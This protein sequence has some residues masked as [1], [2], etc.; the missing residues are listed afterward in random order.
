MRWLRVLHPY[1]KIVSF[2]GILM[3]LPAAVS[4][5]YAD[6]FA[7]QYL[8]IGAA[9]FVFGVAL[10]AATRAFRANLYVRHGFLLINLIWLTL[11]VYATVPLLLIIPDLTFT[12]AYFEAA[13]GLTASGG[14]VL[15]GLDDLPPSLNFWRGE[16]SWIGGMGLVVLATAILPFLGV[17]GSGMYQTELPGPI[18]DNQ[19][20]PHIAQTAKALWLIYFGLTS[21]CALCYYAAGMSGLDAVI[22]SF[23]TM[24]LG[25]FSS[26]DSSFAYFDSPLIE[27]VAITFMILA[28]MNFVT[29]FTAWERRDWRVYWR[30]PEWRA[31]LL[32][33]AVAV[34]A[35]CLYLTYHGVYDSAAE[36][37]RYGVFNT[38]SIVTTTGYSNTD[39]GAWPLFAPLLI[40]MMANFTA[41]SGST[42]GG[43]KLT[44]AIIVFG[45]ASSERTKLIHPYAYYSNPVGRQLPQK[46][47]VSVLFFVLVYTVMTV[48]LMLF[49][50]ATGMDFLTASSAAMASISNTGP[51]LGD[52]GPAANYGGL[53]PAQIWACAFAMLFGRLELMSFFVILN[54]KFWQF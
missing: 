18:K 15:T 46:T 45:Q 22:H 13:S 41:C 26:R 3:C 23:T 4:A 10:T 14:T 32:L 5:L 44:R 9:V 47:L 29:H 54:K 20:T 28:G 19:I 43:I 12:K 50:A 34:A 27:G 36:T 24:G 52:V 40:L 21:V 38:I 16:M 31:Y 39:F 17:G 1:G 53:A 25:G 7:G 6:G 11:P 30:N 35:V 51:G 8:L 33:L 48:A 37:I 2:F 42:G 49:L